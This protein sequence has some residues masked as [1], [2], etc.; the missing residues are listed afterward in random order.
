MHACMRTASTKAQHR[1]LLRGTNGKK[2][3][4][5]RAKSAESLEMKSESEGARSLEDF[6]CH[7]AT[8]M[9]SQ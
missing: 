8:M 5:T 7:G 4:V 1:R 2:F 3:S 9:K 6:E